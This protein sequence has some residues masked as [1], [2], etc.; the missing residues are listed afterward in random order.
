MMSHKV[1][2][3]PKFYVVAMGCTTARWNLGGVVRRLMS[4]YPHLSLLQSL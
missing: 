1:T 4:T 2:L 3:P